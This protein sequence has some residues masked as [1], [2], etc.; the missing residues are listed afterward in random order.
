[1]LKRDIGLAQSESVE[2]GYLFQMVFL[3]VTAVF[4]VGQMYTFVPLQGELSAH[5]GVSTASAALA[6]TVFS[7]S[8]AAGLFILGVL[9]DKYG[10]LPLMRLGMLGSMVCS[11]LLI[12]SDSYASFLTLRG[13]IGFV[14]SAFPPAALG[15][16]MRSMPERYK[17]LTVGF[18]SSGFLVAAIFGQATGQYFIS[19]GGPER[20]FLFQSVSFGAL[21]LLSFITGLKNEIAGG[22][23]LISK[24]VF[25]GKLMH[26]YFTALTLLF[27]FVSVFILLSVHSADILG[28][29]GLT[30]SKLRLITLPL[31]FFPI[32]ASFFI[33]KYGSER[34]LMVGL[35]LLMLGCAVFISASGA[36]QTVT[37]AI[38]AIGGTSVVIP[39]II[40]TIGKYAGESKGTAVSIYAL[41]LFI[42]A[43][44]APVAAGFFSSGQGL[45]VMLTAVSFTALISA[46]RGSR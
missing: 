7:F 38:L 8:Y 3:A 27:L 12:F 31:L 29:I 21:L 28:S 33:G 6:T 14:T 36:G 34:V 10:A 23:K 43:G 17:G 45:A 16:A 19:H 32:V 15:Y 30:V 20:F 44:L 22:K 18:I 25:S 42:G 5:F 46:Y 35:G 40:T 39:S 37:A 9:S 11:V 1:M 13:L 2:Y 26:L 41:L 4:L 24:A